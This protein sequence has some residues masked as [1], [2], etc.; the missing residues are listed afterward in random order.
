M[1]VHADVE[2]VKP[3]GTLALRHGFGESTEINQVM[4]V[5]VVCIGVVRI[6][7]DGV[8]EFPLCGLPVPFLKHG[9]LAQ[10]GVS[11]GESVVKLYCLQSSGLGL[12]VCVLW[13]NCRGSNYIN[14][15]CI[16]IG[17]PGIS[18][19]ELRVL[20]NR[21]IE[22]L[23]APL[24]PFARESV[25][26]IASLQVEFVGFGI[27]AIKLRQMCAVFIAQSQPQLL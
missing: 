3:Q 24:F 27:C 20:L 23:E 2:W 4:R 21:L 18:S 15:R 25:Q 10:S 13:I 14:N 1:M 7:S 16:V 17:Q 22:V 19:G 8:L 6:Q 26:R 12:R 9:N 11:L 5:P